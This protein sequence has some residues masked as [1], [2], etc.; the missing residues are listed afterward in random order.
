MQY[1]ILVKNVWKLLG[2]KWI[3]KDVSLHIP[4]G[5]LIYIYGS[6]GSGKST[7][8]KMLGGLWRPT[9]GEIQI[10]GFPSTSPNAK[11]IVGIVIHENILYD[12]LTVSENLSFHLGFYSSYNE[13]WIADIIDILDIHKVMNK[14]VKE[15]SFGWKRRVNI[16][17]ALLHEP[18]IFIIDEPLTGLDDVGRLSVKKVIHHIVKHGGTVIVASPEVSKYL[19][20]GVNHV[21]YKVSNKNVIPQGSSI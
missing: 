5:R 9:K 1:S 7:F 15:L 10:L 13:R 20:E 4:L 14:K 11:R 18:K 12:E 8:L 17:R 6:N 2:Y 21:L 19:I 3:L 16:I